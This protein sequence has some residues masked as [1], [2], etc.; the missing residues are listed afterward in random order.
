MMTGCAMGTTSNVWSAIED[1]HRR[2]GYA[3]PLG[4]Q[5]AFTRMTKAVALVQGQP[6][7]LIFPA[8]ELCKLSWNSRGLLI[9]KTRDMLICVLGTVG[10]LACQ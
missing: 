7:R 9:L 1:H 5:G 3:H 4:M 8:R 2:V 6:S 10:C